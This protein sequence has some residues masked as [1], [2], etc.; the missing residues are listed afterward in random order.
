MHDKVGASPIHRFAAV[1]GVHIHYVEAGA[2]PL[3]VLLHGFPEFWYAWRRQI[4]P[5][6]AAGFRV[7][8]PD[9]RGYASSSKPRGI[10]AYG[11]RNVADDVQALIARLGAERAH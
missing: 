8:A 3:V 6:A 10:N 1:N 11:I 9:L 7:I 2:G 5:L 4:L